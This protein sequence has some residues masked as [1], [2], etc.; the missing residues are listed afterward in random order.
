MHVVDVVACNNRLVALLKIPKNVCDYALIH[1]ICEFS[2]YKRP[3]YV[4]KR[5]HVR[6]NVLL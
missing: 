2:S 6:Y 4:H 5:E 3:V 1:E